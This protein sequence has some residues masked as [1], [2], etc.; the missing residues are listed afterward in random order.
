[1][2]KRPK[3]QASRADLDVLMVTLEVD[4][5][6]LAECLVETG[7]RLSFPSLSMPA[8]HYN[9][10]GMGEMVVGGDHRV[11]LAPHTLVITPPGRPFQIA[12]APNTSDG[13]AARLKQVEAQLSPD[14]FSGSAHRFVAGSGK[15]E[16]MLICGYFR[17]SYGASINLFESLSTPIVERFDTGDELDHKLKTALAEIGAQQVG[18]GAMTATL[19]KQVLITLLRRSL[20]SSE[21]WLERFATLSDRQVARALASMVARPGAPH[22]VAS[23][24]EVACL[25]RSVFMSRFSSAFGSAPMVALRQLRMRHAANLLKADILSVEQIARAVGY[26]S[27]SSFFRAFQRTYG[28]DP[29][30]FRKA[31]AGKARAEA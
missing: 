13:S 25:S 1:V 2:L 4:I 18:V 22:T 15:S 28:K 3:I 29:T 17:A 7:W 8:I 27:R 21:L 12:V 9:L 20:S 30:D 5:I 16:V 11:P 19:M 23:L 24:A 14:D 26:S 6:L 10:S 31:A